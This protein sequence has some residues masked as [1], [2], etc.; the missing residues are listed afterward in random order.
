MKENKDMETAAAPK[1]P[2]VQ[3]N[4]EQ[5]E[6]VVFKEVS[7]AVLDPD[8]KDFAVLDDYLQI[9]E[10]GR[11]YKTLL[12]RKFK[13]RKRWVAPDPNEI[14]AHIPGEVG[15]ILIKKGDAV[16]KGDKLMIF[17]AMKMKNVITAPFDGII[18]KICVKEEEKLPKGALLIVMGNNSKS[19]KR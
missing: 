15:E 16:K 12:T 7:D 5:K 9:H 19:K 4:E 17:E 10:E 1:Q 8:L 18:K 11:K 14:R 2:A 6:V 13:E 3:E